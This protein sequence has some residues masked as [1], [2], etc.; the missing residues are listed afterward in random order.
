MR[1]KNSRS[2]IASPSAATP[3][4]FEASAA[5]CRRAID[6]GIEVERK[7][8]ELGE[9]LREI[10]EKQLWKST[11]SKNFSAFVVDSVRVSLRTAQE[12]IRVRKAC[13]AVGLSK[14]TIDELGW[15]KL[16]IVASK[17][18]GSNKDQILE[19]IRQKST[20]QLRQIYA[21][22]RPKGAAPGNR[23]A[24]LRITDTIAKAFYCAAIQTGVHD[25]QTNLEHICAE[26][27]AKP[28]LWSLIGE[29]NCN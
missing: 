16:A 23:A 15:S 12:L 19:D 10:Q 9:V 4:N 8:W 22:K 26:F 25:R 24:Q 6:L 3:P 2:H 28:I 21:Q 14:Q 5:V 17:L 20:A 18:T 27:L 11:G 29:I 7:Q 1:E 13:E